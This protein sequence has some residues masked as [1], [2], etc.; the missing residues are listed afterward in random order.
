MW[1]DACQIPLQPELGILKP[2]PWRA[3]AR[4]MFSGDNIYPQRAKAVMCCVRLRM[5]SPRFAMPA[6]VPYDAAWMFRVSLPAQFVPVPR[7]GLH[8]LVQGLRV[9]PGRLPGAVGVLP[10]Q[11]SAACERLLWRRAS[12]LL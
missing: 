2:V 5:G 3:L 10:A 9:C 8:K 1:L 12:S 11:A 7:K 4:D 6:R